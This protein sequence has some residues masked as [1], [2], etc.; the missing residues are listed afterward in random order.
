QLHHYLHDLEIN[1]TPIPDHLRLC[2]RVCELVLR[3]GQARLGHSDLHL[4]NFLMHDG[5]LFLLDGYAVRSGG[6]KMR[7]L[8]MLGHS[9]RR[10]ARLSDLL[11]GWE[12]L[13]PGGAPP[14]RNPLSEFLW[15]RFLQ[16]ITKENRYF[17]KLKI[18][19]LRGVFSKRTKLAYRWSVASRMEI[20]AE[21]WR[22]QLPVLLEQIDQDKLQVIKRSRS[23]DVLAGEVQI[24]GKSLAIIVKRPRRRYWYRYL[25]EIGRGS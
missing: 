21:D 24:G 4:G 12:M 17:G 15:K 1:V 13:G 25:N 22:Q 2:K 18:D 19:G 8:M 14:N 11:R 6:M 9:A 23:G 7:D 3:L 20:G 5:K 16:G 10:F